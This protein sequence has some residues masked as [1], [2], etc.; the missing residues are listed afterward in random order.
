MN[1]FCLLKSVR[2]RYIY[3]LNKCTVAFVNVLIIKNEKNGDQTIFNTL[4]NNFKKHLQ[5]TLQTSHINE[6]DKN[7]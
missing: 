4:K 7:N 5:C 1:V 3:F 6:N 2:W